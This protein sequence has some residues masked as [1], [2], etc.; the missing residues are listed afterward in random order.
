VALTGYLVD[1]SALARV[2]NPAVRDR[3][4]SLATTRPLYRCGI[5]ELEVLGSA[6]SPVDYERRRADLAAGYIDLPMSYSE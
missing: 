5:V 4:E 6:I 3:I 1:T 2:G